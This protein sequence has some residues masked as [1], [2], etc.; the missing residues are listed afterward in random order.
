MKKIIYTLII[1]MLL[2]LP[3]N[4]GSKEFMKKC[5]DSWLGYTTNDIIA[6]WGYPSEERTIAGKHLLYW[7]SS[8]SAY[9]P[10]TSYSNVH[11]YHKNTANV[12]TNTFGG[13][14]VTE[15]CNKTMEVD[16]S[17]KIINWEWTGD[18]CPGSYMTGKKFVNP[19][20]DEWA[21]EKLLKQQMKAEKKRLKMELKQQ[22]NNI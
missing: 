6:V 5:L 19:N 16:N 12:Y 9:I 17:G 8:S 4:A 11:N 21:K 10:Q 7:N 22:Q 3:A 18:A 2:V 20:N 13:Y 15:T 1:S 14:T